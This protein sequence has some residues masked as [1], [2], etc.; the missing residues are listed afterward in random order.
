MNQLLVQNSELAKKLLIAVVIA[1][2]VA[3]LAATYVGRGRGRGGVRAAFVEALML[4]GQSAA[5][6][7]RGTKPVLVLSMVLAIFAAARIAERSTLQFGANGWGTFA[8]GIAV[9]LAGIALRSW[10]VVTLG[11]YF[12]REV[13]V[14]EGQ[15]VVRSGPYRWIRHPAYAGD[16]LFAFGLGLAI[17]SWVAAVAALAIAFAGHL[18]RIRVEE[19]ELTRTLGVEYTEYAESTAR[20]VPGVW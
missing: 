18:P 3:E 14:V 17:G 20:L 19:A 13:V 9:T 1:V 7:D 12:R 8:L 11:R 6:A 16:L 2:P 15:H 5:P 4:R 10:G